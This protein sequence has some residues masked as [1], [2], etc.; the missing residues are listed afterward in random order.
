M[1]RPEFDLQM[2]AEGGGDGAGTAAGTAA[3]DGTGTAE[4]ETGRGLPL[5]DV[6]Y[7]KQA[8]AEQTA[9]SE[10]DQAGNPKT[11]TQMFEDLIKGEYKDEFQRRTQNIINQRFKESKT[12]EEKLQTHDAILNMLA[13]K[14]G[15]DAADVAGLQKAIEADESFFEEEALKRGLSVKQLKE[16][17]QLER[18]NEAFRQAAQQ[19]EMQQR[20]QQIYSQWM[21]Q[22]QDFKTRY[23]LD[24]FS[25]E[26]EIQNAD[27]VNLLKAG[28]SVESAY[29]AVHMD[30]MIGGAMAKTASEVREKMAN[31]IA[32]RQNRTQE[33]GVSSPQS[34]QVFKRD[35]NSLTKADREEIERRVMR[36]AVISF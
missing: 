29:K 26:T 17:K 36:G 8:E 9:A 5:S 10:K 23:G 1:K 20:S 31:S 16:M 21:Q 35:V 19:Q 24:N 4:G 30:D 3:G 25:L 12:L 6:V 22:A 15:V 13:D 32:S 27:F 11:K 2:F 33:N 14:Y 34:T 7:G 28:I 18:E